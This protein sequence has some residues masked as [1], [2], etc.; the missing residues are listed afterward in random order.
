MTAAS[1]QKEGKI[2]IGA[3]DLGR[4]SFMDQISRC[5]GQLRTLYIVNSSSSEATLPESNYAGN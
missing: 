4:L 2:F 3:L 1:G 5:V